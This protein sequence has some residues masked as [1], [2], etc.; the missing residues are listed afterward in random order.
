MGLLFRPRRPL[1]RLAAG[2]TTAG[3]A[4][5][6]GRQRAEQ[7]AYNDQAAAAYA[8]TQPPPAASTPT[9]VDPTLERLQKLTELHAAGELTD[10]EFSAAKAKL[11]GL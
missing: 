1:L 8:A 9:A 4:Y 3:V 6:V 10:T 11:L 7:N 2:A 5:H